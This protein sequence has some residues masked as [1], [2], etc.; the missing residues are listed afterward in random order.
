MTA[1]AASPLLTEYTRVQD[2]LALRVA[3]RALGGMLDSAAVG[4]D[5]DDPWLVR[6]ALVGALAKAWVATG[7][8][9][10]REYGRA[11][12]QHLA[13]DAL[14]PRFADREA[15]ILQRLMLAGATLGEPR[16]VLRARARFDVLLRHAYAKG[17]GVRHTF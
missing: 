2:T 6:A 8:A 12:A 9:R 16:I 15:F 10:Y 11:M 4:S 3:E 13:R 7:D 14:A 5:E 1:E 17:W